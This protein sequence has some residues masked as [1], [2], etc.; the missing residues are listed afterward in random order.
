MLRHTIRFRPL[1]QFWHLCERAV[2]FFVA[3]FSKHGIITPGGRQLV[4]GKARRAFISTFPPLA[5]YLQKY[6]GLT[7]GCQSCG[8]SCKML[9]KCPHWDDSTHLCTVYE[10]RPNI[11]RTFPI[12]PADIRDRAL[13]ST[14]GKPCGF[15]FA[16]SNRRAPIA[17]P[18]PDKQKLAPA[19]NYTKKKE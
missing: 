9:F 12:T 6:Y 16:H 2:P 10:D 17:F 3:V 13:A 11:C 14:N 19:L 8:A 18:R 5:R 4:L 7:G 1:R 15:D